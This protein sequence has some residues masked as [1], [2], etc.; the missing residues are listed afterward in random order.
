MAGTSC[1]ETALRA[2]SPAMTREASPPPD[3]PLDHPHLVLAHAPD[4]ALRRAHRA[5]DRRV[6][7]GRLDRDPG[8]PR[9]RRDQFVPAGRRQARQR[10][11]AAADHWTFIAYATA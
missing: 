7:K 5:V 1:V 11:R 10:T 9:R 2:L 3:L 4:T 6:P 8:F